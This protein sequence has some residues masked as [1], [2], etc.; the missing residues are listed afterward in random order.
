MPFVS[1]ALQIFR[2]RVR[3]HVSQLTKVDATKFLGSRRSKIVRQCVRGHTNRGVSMNKAQRKCN[4]ID[5]HHHNVFSVLSR[6]TSGLCWLYN[7]LIVVLM[8]TRVSQV[9][10]KR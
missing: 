2:I 1:R 5:Y 3:N 9:G 8:F 6:C 4:L 10:I 7:G